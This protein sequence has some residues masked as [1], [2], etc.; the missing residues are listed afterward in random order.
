MEKIIITEIA[1]AGFGSN[2]IERLGLGLGETFR[3]RLAVFEGDKELGNA[4]R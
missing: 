3:L 1:T 4:E 2:N